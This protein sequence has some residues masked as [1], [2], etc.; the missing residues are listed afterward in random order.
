MRL[1]YIT[2]EFLPTWG[3]QGTYSIELIKHLCQM[4]IDIHLITPRRGENYDVEQIATYFKKK[5]TIHNI[6]TA[7]DYFFYNIKFQIG[8]FHYFYRLHKKYHFSIVHISNLVNMPDFFLKLFG[9]HIPTVTT[10]HTT[11]QSQSHIEGTINFDTMMKEPI[12]KLTG[13]LYPAL[14]YCERLYLRKTMNLIAVSSWVKQFIPAKHLHRVRVI[15]NGIDP[16]RFSPRNKDTKDF[17]FLNNINKQI[18]LYT[19][20]LL[21]LKGMEVLMKS[22]KLTLL[23]CDAFFLIAGTGDIGKWERL[24]S[25]VP[26]DNYKF[27]GYVDYT[28]IDSLYANADI[29]LLPSLTESFPLVILEAMA[30]GVPVI[31]TK[32]GGIPEM[33]DDEEN[34]ILI[35]P[36]NPVILSESIVRLLQ[37][38]ALRKN[39][40]QNARAKVVNYFTS[41]IMAENTKKFYEEILYE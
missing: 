36:N 35:E 11:L 34:G 13:L 38:Q 25:G 6:T 9:F 5:V 24:L 17:P 27:L 21:A 10:V 26:E 8:L 32:V 7:K 29:F 20:R 37:N 31:A 23:K 33:I 2:P 14:Q 22:I 3:G 12:E 41:K 15:H 18:V 1:A 19:G 16:E 40:S 39:I 4:G 30:S 28:K